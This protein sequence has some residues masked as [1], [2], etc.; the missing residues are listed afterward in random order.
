MFQDKILSW[1]IVLHGKLPDVE[2]LKNEFE[3]PFCLDIEAL[4]YNPWILNMSCE[5]GTEEFLKVKG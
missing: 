5:L 2:A 3:I 4:I 1:G